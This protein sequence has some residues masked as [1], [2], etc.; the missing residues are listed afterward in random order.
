MTHVSTKIR[1]HNGNLENVQGIWQWMQKIPDGLSSKDRNLQCSSS[2]YK[3]LE[4]SK[5]QSIS[6]YLVAL[7]DRKE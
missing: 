5:T 3:V 2:S 6:T 7:T 1:F 4:I